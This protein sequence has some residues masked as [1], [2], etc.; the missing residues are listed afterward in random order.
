MNRRT[1]W[2]R[3][4]FHWRVA[5]L[6]FLL[7]LV[8]CGTPDWQVSLQ[9]PS[10]A[11]PDRPVPLTLEVTEGGQPVT[12]MHVEARLEMRRMDH[13][14]IDVTLA[15]RKAGRYEGSVDLP[16][17]GEWEAH[18]T[19]TRNGETRTQTVTLTIPEN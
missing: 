18:L 3:F 8:G 17:G 11:D 7:F 4:C 14:L 10:R 13:G 1:A 2:E 15:E 16:M 9:V 19:M 12:G 5:G 6:F